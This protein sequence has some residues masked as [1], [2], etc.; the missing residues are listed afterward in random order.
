MTAEIKTNTQE[1]FP[2]LLG[3]Y[4]GHIYTCDFALLVYR[5]K[6]NIY[7]GI[8]VIGA[9][10]PYSLNGL[11]EDRF[12]SDILTLYYTDPS[13]VKALFNF[14][15][16]YN[17]IF[18][19]CNVPTEKM[20]KAT[21]ELLDT[22]YYEGFGGFDTVAS[23]E[24][25]HRVNNITRTVDI[26]DMLDRKQPSLSLSIYDI[27]KSKFDR[28]YVYDEADGLWY[29]AIITNADELSRDVVGFQHLEKSEFTMEELTQKLK[30]LS[31][32]DKG[33]S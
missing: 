20:I 30:K 4:K 1:K 14:A 31:I 5:S 17:S 10:G 29:Q 33:R 32:K 16:K 8:K 19:N 3:T 7:K 22:F 21:K 9:A 13:K 27:K 28:M 23:I 6:H 26:I 15:S 12:I 24:E 2:E 11:K 25:L 18:L